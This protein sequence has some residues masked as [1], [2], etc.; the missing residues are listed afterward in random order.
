[1]P[2]HERKTLHV[3]D[4]SYYIYRAFH[5]SP[6]LST[7]AGQPTG[8][9]L[10]F[11]NMLRSLIKEYHPD[12]LAV[13]FDPQGVKTFRHE[14]FPDYKGQRSQ[15][16]EDL[17]AQLEFFRP[18]TRALGLAVVELEG[19]EADDVM[20]TL[21]RKASAAGLNAVV[22][23]GDKDLMQLL[24]DEHITLLETMS[25][26]KKTSTRETVVERFGVGPELV[27]DALALA[28]DSSDNI[29]G[30]PG[31]GE[32]TAGKLLAQF[33][34]IDA[35]LSRIDEVP[36][37]KRKENLAAHSDA[38]RLYR[39]LTEVRDDLDVA[40][41]LDA[42]TVGPPD[43]EA[44]LPLL[45]SLEFY[46][47]ID[48]LELR[49]SAES[50]KKNYEM[51]LTQKQLDEVLSSL[52]EVEV[53]CV[54]LET[55]SIDPTRADIVGVALAWRPDH[56]VYI[57]LTHRYL[58]APE[59]LDR[60][61]VLEAL[62]PLIEGETPKKVGQHTK[63][64]HMVFARAGL[65]LR[66]VSQDTMLMSYLLEPGR[67]SHSLDALASEMLYHQTITFEDVAGKGK[68]Q[69]RFDQVEVERATPY[70]A[71][72]ADITL[73]LARHMTPLMDETLTKLHDE[74]ELPLARV[75]ADMERRGVRIND[76]HL[77]ALSDEFLKEMNRLEAEAHTLVGSTFNLNSPK[78]LAKILYEDLGL[79]PTN[80]RRTKH[81]FS[82]NQETLESL[83][84]SH[85]LPALVLEYRSVSK[86]RSTYAEAIPALVNPETG[87]VHTSFNQA[88]AATGR[89][90]SSGPNLQN[91]PSRTEQ[92]RR[93]RRGFIPQ[94]GWRFLAADYSQIELRLMADLSRDPTMTE[95]FLTG[96]DIHA[97]TASAI[98]GVALDEVTREQ[99]GAAKT[100]NFGV[101]YGM[102]T[103][104]L[105]RSLGL[106]HE[107]AE[108]IIDSFHQRF[109]AVQ[110][111]FATLI[112]D[113]RRDGFVTTLLGRK[114]FIPEL[115]SK[116]SHLQSLGE[117]LAINTPIQG[118]AAD[119]IKLAM[120]RVQRR[121]QDEQLAARML[122]QVH[123]E[124]VFE[125][126]P[127]ELNTLADLVREEMEGVWA[128]SIPLL[129]EVSV[130]EN[131][132]D[133][134]K[135]NPKDLG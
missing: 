33:G 64:E 109:A 59:Q 102:G 110:A 87:R 30:I 131:W 121:L 78:Q 135:L 12:Y 37:K 40:L 119:L 96:Q 63:Y 61:A 116:R 120:I 86:L 106:T 91:I 19:F 24:D 35:I 14:L 32:K 11:I 134:E 31:I 10:I 49:G 58:G 92:G 42:F 72:D 23:S 82:T 83:E 36:G 6:S 107:A 39:K 97:R 81:G 103:G 76:A 70:A 56:G 94:E 27:P 71:E 74:V 65:T 126:P 55:T 105:A 22:V 118:T 68:K 66:G 122:L 95:A 48:D 45:D 85:A 57:P 108:A 112:E 62:R 8:G 5:A 13:A 93:L 133:M 15:D 3:V 25:S 67:K 47:L 18:L 1:M 98:F 9:L 124:L 129:V 60:A 17:K 132:A 80:K 127:E 88:V 7:R 54:D 29:P 84:D 43:A 2:E 89:L 100:I 117:R 34:S 104:R 51:I 123:D 130:G 75:L 41:D 46:R 115:N 16:P 114:R 101:L 53:F 28:G 50:P 20:A 44:L 79:V 73:A 52:R 125:A 128:L 4:G 99:R 69:R 21:A 26:R 111:Y 90:S 38:L 77:K 113:A